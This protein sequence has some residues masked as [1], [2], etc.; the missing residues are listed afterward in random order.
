MKVLLSEGASLS[1]RQAIFALGPTGTRIEVCDP[2]PFCLGRFSRFVRAWHRCPHWNVDPVGYLRFLADRLAAERYDVLLAI[3]DQ[4]F[5]LARFRED[6]GRLVGLALPDFAALE[7]LQSKAEFLRVLD[8]LN[9][10]HPPTVLVRTRHELEAVGTS[11]CYIKLAYSTAGCGVWRVC[12]RGEMSVVAGRLEATGLLDGRFEVLVQQPSP[13]VLRVIQAV[14]QRGRLVGAHCSQARAQGVGGSAWARESVVDPLVLEHLAALGSHLDWHGGLCMDYL[15]DPETGQVSYID[16]NPRPGET[17][18]ATL[19]GLNLSERLVQ[20]SLEQ[21]VPTPP[22]P[23]SGV[24]THTYVMGLMALAHDG[25]SRRRL[26]AELRRAWAQQAPYDA[27]QDEI[28]RPRQDPPSLIPAIYLTL[29]LLLNPS[30]S[31]RIVARTV[32][33]Y[34]LSEAA[35]QLIRQ[36]PVDFLARQSIVKR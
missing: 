11:P 7:R 12:D 25:A 36:I 20:V 31:R 10:P 2:D 28:T 24:R 19:S 21:D 1:A 13:G 32:D 16:A 23:R 17:L 35:V 5:L 30:A 3:H 6:L 33:N 18:N 15:H 8:E 14:Y 29:R 34:S 27:S 9:L 22:L 4:A 26:L